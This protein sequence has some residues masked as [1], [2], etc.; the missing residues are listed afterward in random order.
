MLKLLPNLCLLDYFTPYNSETLNQ[1]NDDLRSGS[2]LVI[3]NSHL[4]CS[5]GKESILYLFNQNSL[6]K[7]D[8]NSPSHTRTDK[9]LKKVLVSTAPSATYHIY[10]APTYY[11]KLSRTR[12]YVWA[13]NDNM[14]SYLFDGSTISQDP[15]SATNI[16]NLK[17]V[18]SRS[19]G[20]PSSFHAV[21][22]NSNVAGT[23]V[24]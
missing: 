10:G 12:L 13:E 22:A 14:K 3:P 19:V 11:P 4:C 1:N 5:G 8:L 18:F 7:A 17:N 23:G 20:M 9:V 21:L 24:L 2:I 16:L 15:A 6:S